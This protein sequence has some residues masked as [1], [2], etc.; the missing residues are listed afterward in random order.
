LYAR[1]GSYH[2][3]PV[4]LKPILISNARLGS[5]KRL[6]KDKDSSLFAC[7]WQGKISLYHRYQMSQD[8]ALPEAKPIIAPTVITTQVASSEEF[9]N[10]EQML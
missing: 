2:E 3:V 10:Q 8:L 4:W 9:F 7:Q 1:P 6:G 5:L